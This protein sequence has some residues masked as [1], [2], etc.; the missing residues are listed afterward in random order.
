VLELFRWTYLFTVANAAVK[1]IL[2]LYALPLLNMLQLARRKPFQP[3]SV[4]FITSLVRKNAVGLVHNM[5][6]AFSLGI[7]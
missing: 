5:S 7:E 1:L 4:C 6:W 3:E 2:L